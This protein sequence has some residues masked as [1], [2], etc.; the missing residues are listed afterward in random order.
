[1]ADSRDYYS[2][3]EE[4][5][6]LQMAAND[7]CTTNAGIPYKELLDMT[8]AA[9]EAAAAIRLAKEN[10]NRYGI[11]EDMKDY[12]DIVF[13]SADKTKTEPDSSTEQDTSAETDMGRKP[14]SKAQSTK[15]NKGNG[16]RKKMDEFDEYKEWPVVVFY[17]P[18]YGPTVSRDQIARRGF[19]LEDPYYR[20][21]RFLDT[22]YIICFNQTD[23]TEKDGKYYLIGPSAIYAVDKDEQ[24]RSLTEDEVMEIVAICL[25]KEERI[26]GGITAA[27]RLC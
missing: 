18:G 13:P 6:E 21:M 25:H 3:I 12:S 2:I 5:N 1:M 19:D 23:T 17:Y 14:D 10:I 8:I 27:F 11:P 20:E 4:M 15:K 16:G 7:I 9:V 24:I 22:D 26:D